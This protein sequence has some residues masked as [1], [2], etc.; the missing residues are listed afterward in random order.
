MTLLLWPS[1]HECEGPSSF[2]LRIA[3]T[4][5]LTFRA[6]EGAI[7]DH[8]GTVAERRITERWSTLKQEPSLWIYRRSRWCPRCLDSTGYGRLGWELLFADACASCGH[9]LADIC[10]TCGSAVT[11]NRASLGYCKC[12]QGLARQPSSLA[13]PAVWRL[14]RS[15]EQLC[16]GQTVEEIAQL[17]GLSPL[18]CTKLIRLIGAYGN[19]NLERTPQ[20]I[21]RADQLDVSWRISSIAAEV[22]ADWPTQFYRFLGLQASRSPESALSG[23]MSGVFGGFY[24]TLYQNLRGSEFDWVRTAFESFIANSWTGAMGRR[25]K[26]MPETQRSQLAWLPLSNA[27]GLG[28]LS[29]RQIL[30]LSNAGAIKVARRRTRSGREFTM[31]RRS[32][33]EALDTGHRTE[34]SLVEAAVC[35][36]IKRQRLSRWLPIVCPSARKTTLAG[37]PWLIPNSWVQA[38]NVRLSHLESLTAVPSSAISLD[39]LFRYGPLGEE[40]LTQLI[41]DLEREKFSAIGRDPRHN[42]LPSLLF[43]RT[44]LLAKYLATGNTVISIPD[45]AKSLGVKQ[46]VGY[47]LARL[48]LLETLP[49]V[50]GRRNARRVSAESIR[51]FQAE[52]VF[53]TM[54]AKLRGSSS[55]TIA[56]ELAERG[57]APVA[58]RAIGNCRQI[59]YRRADLLSVD[60][61]QKLMSIG[62]VQAAS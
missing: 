29:K 9:W 21:T 15:L 28:Y 25:N 11:W 37:T 59:V 38:W 52:Y 62:L 36:G 12:G 18:Q 20:K 8:A 32:D 6:V 50:V 56:A 33:L 41:V 3:E 10:L 24:R 31:V 46:E 53:A 23:R 14:S 4:N 60:W 48:S 16:L 42:G 44:D 34:M 7:F 40:Q 19:S 30:D 2:R 58:S 17:R 54:L 61:V 26:R 22:F 57:I 47:A 43:D 13:P 27:A 39:R 5:M 35:L 55:T 1:A 51:K 45:A 49:T